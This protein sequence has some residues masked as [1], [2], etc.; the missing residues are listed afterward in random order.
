MKTA[1]LRNMNRDELIAKQISLK[2]ELMNFRF[3]AKMGKLDKPSKISQARK[4]IARILTIL[5][6]A[7][8]AKQ[9]KSQKA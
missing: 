9:T 7:S 3:Q 8:H 4:D 1:D 5:K 6:E 2:E